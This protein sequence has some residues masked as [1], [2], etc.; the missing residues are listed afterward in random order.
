MLP[1][2]RAT[3]GS[4]TSSLGTCSGITPS[5]FCSTR[6]WAFAARSPNCCTPIFDLIMADK[7]HY[8]RRTRELFEDLGLKGAGYRNASNRRQKLEQAIG[9]IQGVWL[10]TGR[11][12]AVAI[13]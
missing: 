6:F 7:T 9:E 1:K 4:T 5:P 11:L 13:E 8:E 10:S 2:R 3:F 12:S